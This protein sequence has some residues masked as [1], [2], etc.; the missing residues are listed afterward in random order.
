MLNLLNKR[1]IKIVFTKF[2]EKREASYSSIYDE[3]DILEE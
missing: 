2:K 3:N 1:E